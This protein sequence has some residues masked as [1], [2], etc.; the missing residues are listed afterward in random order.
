MVVARSLVPTGLFDYIGSLFLRATQGSGKRFLLGLLLLVAPLCAVLPNA[1]TVGFSAPLY[2]HPGG[3][4][5][6]SGFGCAAGA[7]GNRE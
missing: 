5:A 4:G 2:Y 3:L 7:D 6:E 1:T